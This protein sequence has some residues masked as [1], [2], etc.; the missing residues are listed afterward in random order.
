MWK[1]AG[2][3]GAWGVEDANNPKNPSYKKV[4]SESTLAGYHGIELGPY[5]FLPQDEDILKK[6]LKRY[7]LF[8]IAGTIYE[9]LV[10]IDNLEEVLRKTE[11]TCRLLSKLPK[12]HQIKDQKYETPYLVVIDAVNEKRNPY[13]GHPF[14]APRLSKPG[15]ENLVKH[16]KEV[17]KI[18]KKYG[19]RPVIHPHAGGYIEFEDEIEFIMDTLKKEDVGL[20]L[21]TGHL[22][23]SKMD[24]SRW[25][26]KY[27]NRLEY[28]HF[29]DI[30]KDLYKGVLESYT[31]FF[32]GCEKG[33]MCPIGMGCIDYEGI[34]KTLEEIGYRGW[35]TIEQE[36]DPL[37][38]SGSL[39]D[40]KKSIT[41]LN[42]Q[43]YNL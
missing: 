32:E 2:A 23:Y 21:D 9:D 42:N 10:S 28:L 6:E 12:P 20:C 43:G 35:I 13:A 25:L 29:K 19:V 1:I 5:G 30:D 37:L 31:G 7:N 33:V 17:A 38:A 14:E 39:D 36:R 8:I 26:K 11:V 24:P 22:F 4:L 18:A 3:P 27:S 41:Y 40:A 16:I 34:R 15:S